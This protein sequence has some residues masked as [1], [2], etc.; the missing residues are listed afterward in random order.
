MRTTQFTLLL[1][2]LALSSSAIR[3]LQAASWLTNAPMASERKWHSAT[4]LPNGKVL[5][6]GGVTNYVAPFYLTSATAE[7]YDPA[8]GKWTATAPMRWPRALHTAT[9]LP[10]GKVLVAGGYDFAADTSLATAELYDPATG[11]WTATDPMTTEREEHRAVLLASGKVLVAGGTGGI[12]FLG[13]SELYDPATGKWTA[14]GTPGLGRYDFTFTLLP[15][16]QVLAAG[17]F[18]GVNQRLAVAELYNPDD[19]VWTATNPLSTPREGHTAT[20]LPNGLVL[21]AGGIG[22]NTTAINSVELFDPATQTWTTTNHLNTARGNHTAT[23]LPNGNVLAAS[24]DITGDSAELY[25]PATGLWTATDRLNSSRHS[26][27][28]TMLAS[29]RVLVVGGVSTNGFLPSTELF[30]SA[31]GTWMP[32]SAM[33]QARVNCTATLLSDGRVL[34]AGDTIHRNASSVEL[35][36]PSAGRWTN[37][38]TMN[39]SH[40]LHTA[41][42]LPDGSVL[43]AGGENADLTAKPVSERF[44]PGSGTWTTT[45][46]LN[47]ARYAHAATLLRNGKVLVTGGYDWNGSPV[48]LASTETYQPGSGTWTTTRSMNTARYLHTA[49]R[50]T[51]GRVLVVG[52]ELYGLA[53]SSAEIY[54]PASGVWMPAASLGVARVCHTTTL[55]PN[56]YVL[57]VGGYTEIVSTGATT[58][59]SAELYDPLKGTWTATGTMIGAHADHTAI[60]LPNGQVLVA[61][62]FDQGTGA[63]STAELYDPATGKWAAIGNMGSARCYHAA[64]LLAD[65]KPLLVGGFNGTSI[66]SEAELYDAGLAFTSALQPQ[67]LSATSPLALGSSLTLTGSG[68]RGVSGGSSGGMQDSP[69]DYPLVQL[70]SIESGQTSYLLATQWQTNSFQSVPVW[71]FPPGF[72]LATVFVNGIPSTGAVVSISV[73]VPTTTSLT[74]PRRLTN[75]AFQFAFTNSVG[76]IFSV[77]AATNPALPLTNWTALGGVA[78]VA[79]GQFQFTDPQA[80]NTPSRFYRVR[81]L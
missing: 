12:N 74:D 78:E 54:D 41:T 76:A 6:A 32:T 18:D 10:N 65:G 60:L 11:T 45:G 17:G 35:Y 52:G 79:P 39:S 77:L 27:T 68:F 51:D 7:L 59:A 75:G 26:Q 8:N 71:D 23:L 13:P 43:V 25:D 80:T 2:T 55:L 16:G 4:L 15:N 70:R 63:S 66:S 46:P 19:G 1:V 48:C 44:H 29:G 56:G 64:T 40:Y 61:G 37:T 3:P 57:V 34:V 22:T 36:Y 50:L 53:L 24:G 67:I 72:A 5:V 28:A 38:A 31:N 73:P 14:T 69:T 62:G 9:L 49:T 33:N 20:L 21:V 81:S 30:D 47:T 58:V 42:L